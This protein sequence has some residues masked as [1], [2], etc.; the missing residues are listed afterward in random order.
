MRPFR[1]FWSKAATGSGEKNMANQSL[2]P[3][4]MP[5]EPD[6]RVL[7][8]EAD[9]GSRKENATN[10]KREPGSEPMRTGNAPDQTA[11]ACGAIRPMSDP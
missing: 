11:V 5:A 9:T 10:Q 3:V 2:D 8:N 1:A 6:A 4:L 7:L